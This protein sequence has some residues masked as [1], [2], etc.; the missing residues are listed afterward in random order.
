MLFIRRSFGSLVCVAG[1]LAVTSGITGKASSEDVQKPSREMLIKL[2]E[3]KAKLPVL[4]EKWEKDNT[5]K[6]LRNSKAEIALERWIGENEVKLWIVSK[7]IYEEIRGN[8]PPD[9]TQTLALSFRYYDGR[10]TTMG[11]PIWDHLD[12]STIMFAID[13]F[14]E[15]KQPK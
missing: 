14:T 9:R 10:W 13:Q 1:F 2:K 11:N 15:I 8:Q 12:L 6:V 3:L 5:T 7:C 4:V